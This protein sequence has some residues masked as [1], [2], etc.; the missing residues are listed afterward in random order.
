MC[1]NAMS[2]LKTLSALKKIIKKFKKQK[3][4][5]V[6]TNGCF[7][8]IH[9]GHIQLLAQAAKKG[10]ILVVGLNSDISV[11]KIKGKS[12]PIMDERSRVRILEAIEVIDYIIFFNEAT[13]YSLIKALRPD[14]LVTGQ[15]WS[16]G[17][18]VGKDLVGQVFRVKLLPR[19]STSGI[20]RKIKKSG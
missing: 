17:A 5:I 15:D 3:K 4:R 20:I 9:P 6:F 13:P 19:Y 8:L 10:D 12:R 1:D 14:V 2:K 11:K 18:I 16:G 7:D